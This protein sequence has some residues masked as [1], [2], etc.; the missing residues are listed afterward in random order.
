V[1]NLDKNHITIG[2]RKIGI[3]NP[4]YVVAEISANHNQDLAIAKK[5]V[6]AAKNCGADAVKLQTYTPDT[7]TLDVD[8]DYFRIKSDNEW[9][10]KTLYE[11]YGEAYTPWEW[12][13]DLM[14]L[15]KKLGIPVFSTP[16]DRTAIDFL[17]EIDCPAYKIASF[18]VTDLPLVRKAAKTGKPL[19]MSTGLA[20]LAELDEAVQIIKESGNDLALLHCTSAYPAPPSEMNLFKIPFLRQT[21]GVPTGLSDH[22]LG[23][24]IAIA[25]IAFGASIIEKH[26]IL[27]RN[28]GG[29]DYFFSIE[30][31]ELSL[32]I[33][34]V[35]N[36][37]EALGAVT[38]RMGEKEEKNRVFRRSIFAA[39]DISAGETITQENVRIIRPAYGLSPKYWNIVVGRRVSKDISKGTPVS[40][41]M[42]LN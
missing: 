41:D 39:R 29:P 34:A 17:E 11:L 7:M 3:D 33:R 5:M 22:Y 15:G 18:E 16:F 1:F 6:K 40:W 42:I 25:S 36:V 9:D 23:T 30:P 8:N 19:I 31:S 27:D 21:F 32:L 12:H 20:S 24:E 10:G 26:F 2:K 13:E 4:P 28:L 35:K 38:F 37:K 14:A